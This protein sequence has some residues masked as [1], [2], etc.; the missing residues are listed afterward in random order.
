MESVVGN[1][2]MFD[3]PE[4]EKNERCRI[5]E[6]SRVVLNKEID[7]AAEYDVVVCGGGPAGW[8]AAVSAARCGCRTALIE[9][10]GFLGGTATAG[11]VVPL[12][13]CYFRGERVVGGIA[14][15]F[16]RELEALGAAQVELPKGHISFHPEYFKLVAQRM[17]RE[18][19][20]QV[21]T[22]TYLCDC[23]MEDSRVRYVLVQNKGGLQAIGG[24]CF[25]D[26]TGDGD[27][28]HL[29]G[30]PML[31]QAQQG[32]QPVSLCFL[33][34]GVDTET[35]LLRDCIRHDGKNGK[36]SCNQTIRDCLQRRC[37][38]LGDMQ[39]GGP[40]FNTLHRGGCLAVNMT[41]AGVDATDPKA[42]TE[43][44][45]TLRRDMFTLVGILK[46]EFPEFRNCEIVSS[47]VNA[48][49][50]ETRRIRGLYTMTAEDVAN[51]VY[52]A[53]PVAHCAHPMDIH[54]AKGSAQSLVQLEKNVYVPYE[55]MVCREVDNLIAAGRCISV[56]REPYASIRVMGTLMSIGEAAGVAAKLQ[57]ECGCPVA[58]LPRD[59]LH[60]RIQSRKAF[61]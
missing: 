59:V 8:V 36:P 21:Y 7:I 49:I 56:E 27:L 23:V 55:T 3:A 32:L 10:Y 6:N 42:Y 48:G 17:V 5:V 57:T 9:R 18:S 43:A 30:V 31:E 33:L 61:L 12:S 24:S 54:S 41:R 58:E 44:E 37:A 34:E 13:G 16:V 2:G 28:C 4:Y 50:R 39:F 46:E 60:E 45:Y 22:N 11:L 15:E 20:V 25:I 26:A 52:P 29:S 53:C 40:W 38:A 51:P 19:G 1:A 14:W 47:A 35:E